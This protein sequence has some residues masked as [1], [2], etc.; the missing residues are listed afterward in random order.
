MRAAKSEGLEDL[1]A[2]DDGWRKTRAFG[3]VAY[4]KRVEAP[5]SGIPLLLLAL[6]VGNIPLGIHFRTHGPWGVVV[7][8]VLD[9]AK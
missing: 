1:V 6:R 2:A 5:A 9:E 4:A 8:D 3:H 7:I